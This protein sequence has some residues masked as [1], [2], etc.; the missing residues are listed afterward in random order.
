MSKMYRNDTRILEETGTNRNY[1]GE[2][3]NSNLV[4]TSKFLTIQK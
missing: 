3:T 1:H 2:L 4:L